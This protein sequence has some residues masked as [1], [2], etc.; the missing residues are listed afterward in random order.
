MNDVGTFRCFISSITERDPVLIERSNLV[1]I[2]KLVV[3]EVSSLSPMRWS[4]LSS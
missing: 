1:N 3:K 4:V 2:S